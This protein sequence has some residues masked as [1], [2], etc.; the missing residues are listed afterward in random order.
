[1]RPSRTSTGRSSSRARRAGRALAPD[2]PGQRAQV[3]RRA[4]LDR[5]EA[6]ARAHGRA[7]GPLSAPERPRL[8]DRGAVRDVD[9]SARRRRGRERGFARRSSSPS[10]GAPRALE[11]SSPVRTGSRPTRGTRLERAASLPST[12]PTNPCART[13]GERAPHRLR[14]SG[15]RGVARM[16]KP[17]RRAHRPAERPRSRHGDLRG[18]V[19]PCALLGRF[20]EALDAVAKHMPTCLGA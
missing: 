2:R 1:M 19:P 11:R 16:G 13:H 7:T 6:S 12:R 18:A 20:A 15:L 9:E 5:D 14:G 3:R 4:V 8:P 10:P 17:T